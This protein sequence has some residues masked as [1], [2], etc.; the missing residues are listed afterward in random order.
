MLLLLVGSALAQETLVR[1]DGRP[2]ARLTWSSPGGSCEDIGPT[3]RAPGWVEGDWV[4]LSETPGTLVLCYAGDV[5]RI[6]WR[7][8]PT[9]ADQRRVAE[10][11]GQV[12]SSSP[13][14]AAEQLPT[15]QFFFAGQAHA[16][17]GGTS[18]WDAAL[19]VESHLAGGVGDPMA[20]LLSAGLVGGPSAAFG[21]HAEVLLGPGRWVTRRVA[22]AALVG[23]RLEGQYGVL[24]FAAQLP[25]EGRLLVDPHRLLRVDTHARASAGW[26]LDPRRR[27]L[28]HEDWSVGLDLW[29]GPRGNSWQVVVGSELRQV[30]DG[31][32]VGVFVGVGGAEL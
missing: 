11:I 19:A 7:L 26:S 23:P 24:P 15:V 14:F 8:S 31:Q 13:R 32:R 17:R 27:T 20:G 4:A 1:D 5:V 6:D 2:I 28:P 25:V 30:M 12:G 16:W 21:G 18:P 3:S 10:A 29:F 22:V 9:R